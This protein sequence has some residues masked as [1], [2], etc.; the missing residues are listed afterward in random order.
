MQALPENVRESYA[1]PASSYS[2]GWSH[3]KASESSVIANIRLHARTYIH[4]CPQ[5]SMHQIG[6][7]VALHIFLGDHSICVVDP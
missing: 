3:G 1:D 5:T 6:L 4:P 2:F 7:S